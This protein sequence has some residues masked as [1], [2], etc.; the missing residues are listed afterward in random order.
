M[1][2]PRVIVDISAEGRVRLGQLGKSGTQVTK[3]SMIIQ[4]PPLKLRE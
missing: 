1:P 4:P 2:A 3:P